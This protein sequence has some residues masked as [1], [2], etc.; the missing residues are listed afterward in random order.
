MSHNGHTI[1]G[2][3]VRPARPRVGGAGD[4]RP[5]ILIAEDDD[6]FRS[7]LAE[8][9]RYEGYAVVE[10][11]NGHDLLDEL[12]TMITDQTPGII[13]DLII[14]DVRMPGLG[15]IETLSLLR[16]QSWLPPVI[17]MTAFGGEDVRLRARRVGARDVLFKPIDFDEIVALCETYAPP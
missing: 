7:L 15:G 1:R 9:L 16:D 8:R 5:T 11:Q 14:S 2:G 12:G 13:P 10:A 6:E 3:T 4:N 17:L